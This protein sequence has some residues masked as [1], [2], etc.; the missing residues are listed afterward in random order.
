MFIFPLCHQNPP[1]HLR[2]KF[3][4][5]HNV[6]ILDDYLLIIKILT[7]FTR[8]LT[9]HRTPNAKPGEVTD[10]ADMLVTIVVVFYRS[11]KSA[12]YSQE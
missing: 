6:S 12:N 8:E 4:I 7:R 5:W 2:T 10:K 11:S 9:G 1:E 3:C